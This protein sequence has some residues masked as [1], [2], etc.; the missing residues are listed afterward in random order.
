MLDLSLNV[1]K[2]SCLRI[3]PRFNVRCASISAGSNG[4]SW[5]SNIRYLGVFISCGRVFRCNLDNCRSN[6][7]RSFNGIFSKIGTSSSPNVILSL[8]SSYCLP[9]LLYGLEALSVI[10]REFQR[11]EL[12][13][14]RAFMKIFSSYNL[15][16]IKQC[17]Y[18][19]GYLPLRYIYEIRKLNFLFSVLNTDNCLFGP[20]QTVAYFD[21]CN[22]LKLYNCNFSESMNTIKR[23][24]WISF[25]TDVLS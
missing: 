15:H 19:S 9:V 21:I 23:K 22:I 8:M 4:V 2:S 17:Q 6:F 16:V 7:Y 10:S 13:Y 1:S 14:N 25:E 24:I 5:C 3:G 11:L 12:A 20:F 18:Y